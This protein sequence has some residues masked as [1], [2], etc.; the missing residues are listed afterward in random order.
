MT[1]ATDFDPHVLHE[2]GP[3][4]DCSECRI[5]KNHHD[6]WAAALAAGP[7]SDLDAV[8]LSEI[9]RQ[10][11]IAWRPTDDEPK[12]K[13]NKE[14]LFN[15]FVVNHHGEDVDLQQIMAETEAAQGTAYN[16]IREMAIQ[17]RRIGTSRYHVTDPVRARAEALS[18]SGATLPQDRF[19]AGTSINT[20]PIPPTPNRE[21]SKP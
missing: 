19:R 11:W 16:Y 3:H 2:P 1:T 6:R 12:T 5:N 17:F 13:H 18:G 15:A 10:E 9:T 20:A 14:Q 7:I 8:A 21:P 4:E